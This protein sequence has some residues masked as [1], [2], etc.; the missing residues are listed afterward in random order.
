MFHFRCFLCGGD[1]D[2]VPLRGYLAQWQRSDAPRLWMLLAIVEK[3]LHAV[4]QGSARWL[5]KRFRR[6]SEQF[7]AG[8][9]QAQLPLPDI[10]CCPLRRSRTDERVLTFDQV[11]PACFT[12]AG[13]RAT[14][15]YFTDWPEACKVQTGN[16]LYESGLVLWAVLHS[17]P[18]WASGAMLADL[19]RVRLG[20]RKVGGALSLLEC[21]QCGRFTSCLHGHPDPEENG[22]CRWCLD[23]GGGLGGFM[24]ITVDENGL[25]CPVVECDHTAPARNCWDVLPPEVKSKIQAQQEDGQQG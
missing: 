9:A 17:L 18:D 16:V 13:R 15:N 8:L 3:A 5:T 14:G 2:E 10:G 24:S 4:E 25:P 23:M 22:F 1:P 20:L 12:G 6:A 11:C 21:P 7:R 19:N